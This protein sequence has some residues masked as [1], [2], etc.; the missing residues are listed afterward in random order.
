M[1]TKGTN[2]STHHVNIVDMNSKT[3]AAAYFAGMKR[4]SL[5]QFQNLFEVRE[6]K[7]SNSKN[8]L[9]G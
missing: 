1:Y 2:E 7:D 8:L 5:H 6:I 3:E 9:L 4:L